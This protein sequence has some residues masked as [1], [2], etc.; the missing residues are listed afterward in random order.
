MKKGHKRI[1]P[2]C[3]K[4]IKPKPQIPKKVHYEYEHCNTVTDKCSFTTDRDK[5]TCLNCIH[6]IEAIELG[7][8]VECPD[9]HNVMKCNRYNPP[10]FCDNCGKK[11]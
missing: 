1:C 3:G 2:H 9:C 8:M 5:V 11:L 7:F 10:K 6:I 4:E